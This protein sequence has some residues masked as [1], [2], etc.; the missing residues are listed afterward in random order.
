MTLMSTEDLRAMDLLDRAG[1][2]VGGVRDVLLDG[3]TGRL[4]Y[5]VIA[6]GQAGLAGTL[7]I[8]ERLVPVPVAALR[9]EAGRMVLS[10]DATALAAAPSYARSHPPSFDAA[11]CD[12]L[13][14]FWGVAPGEGDGDSAMPDV[15]AADLANLQSPRV[16]AAAD[17]TTVSRALAARGAEAAS[18][19]DE[20]GQ[21]LGIVTLRDIALALGRAHDPAARRTDTPAPSSQSAARAGDEMDRMEA[22]RE[23]TQAA[24]SRAPDTTP[25]AQPV[26][27][28][29]PPAPDSQPSSDDPEQPPVVPAATGPQATPALDVTSCP[30]CGVHIR[31][32]AAYCGSCGVSLR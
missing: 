25:V 3:A 22:P 24:V 8:G 1:R 21:G 5:A 19:V 23:P 10:R 9:L 15:T 29:S 28:A 20:R 11:Y 12:Q 32:G 6:V 7:G 4:R 18:V 17:L 16:S 27:G 14:T 26:N 31:A 2:R 13:A 30:R